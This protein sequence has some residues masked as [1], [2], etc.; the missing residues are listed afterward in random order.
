MRASPVAAVIFLLLAGTEPA[1][2]QGEAA[3]VLATDSPHNQPVHIPDV[4]RV[5]VVQM[6]DGLGALLL[7][8][9]EEARA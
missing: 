9:A 2:C 1:W 3:A 6:T 7:C 5:T 4:A 8:P